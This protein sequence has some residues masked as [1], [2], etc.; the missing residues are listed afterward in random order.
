M[1][2]PPQN[3]P[4]PL[5]TST[6]VRQTNRTVATA[7]RPSHTYNLTAAHKATR[8]SGSTWLSRTKMPVYTPSASRTAETLRAVSQRRACSVAP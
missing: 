8:Y 7:T 6:T 3:P 5:V 2:T 4:T 1:T